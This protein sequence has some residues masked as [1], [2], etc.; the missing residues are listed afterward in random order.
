MHIQ[1][2]LPYRLQ[3]TEAAWDSPPLP[4]PPPISH[5]LNPSPTQPGATEDLAS[6]MIQ[7]IRPL[8]TTKNGMSVVIYMN[9]DRIFKSHNVGQIIRGSISSYLPGV[10]SLNLPSV[11]TRKRTIQYSPGSQTPSRVISTVRA[12]RERKCEMYVLPEW[13]RTNTLDF[14]GYRIIV[15][16]CML[17][18]VALLA[19]IGSNI[20]AIG[21]FQITCVLIGSFQSSILAIDSRC[22]SVCLYYWYDLFIFLSMYILG[23]GRCHVLVFPV[24]RLVLH[25]CDLLCQNILDDKVSLVIL[26]K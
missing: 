22:G 2:C 12:L 19:C 26:Q 24:S 14:S 6:L 20:V 9:P 13:A 3:K 7:V 11:S 10:N 23:G 4:P 16:H 25:T 15:H 18:L 1:T 17:R 21:S 8:A 5:T